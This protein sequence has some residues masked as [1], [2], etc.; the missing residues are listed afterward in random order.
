MVK[1]INGKVQPETK[2]AAFIAATEASVYVPL[3][4]RMLS[5]DADG[6]CTD[7]CAN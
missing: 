5:F 4:G 6:V 1:F 3:S 7:G 2:T